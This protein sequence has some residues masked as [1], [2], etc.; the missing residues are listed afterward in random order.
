MFGRRSRWIAVALAASAIATLALA[1]AGTAGADQASKCANLIMPASV[2]SDLRATFLKQPGLRG[3]R[4]VSQRGTFYGVCGLTEYAI[5]TYKASSRLSSK[6]AALFK[7]QPDIYRRGANNTAFKIIGNT[8]GK[9]KSVP[10]GLAKV[11]Q[12]LARAWGMSCQ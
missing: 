2:S 6:Q 4:V 5:A 3:V 11:P 1:S 10:C 9:T 12:D 8:K 7:N